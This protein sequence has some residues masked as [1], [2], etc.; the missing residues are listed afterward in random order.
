MKPALVT[1]SNSQIPD[2]LRAQFDV[3]VVPIPV[4]VN[5]VDYLEGIDL[6]ADGFYEFFADGNTPEVSTSQP[7]PG[8]FVAAYQRCIDRGHDEIV[9]VHVAEAFSG[10]INAARI[11]AD[12]VD[13]TVHLVDSATASFGV[14]CCAWQAGL[15]RDAGGDATA[16]VAA[17]ETTAERLHSVTALGAAALLDQSGRVDLDLSDDG[18]HMF[19]TGPGGAFDSIG[20]ATTVD[21]VCDRVAGAMHLDGAPIRVALG[22]ADASSLPYYGEL[23]ARL[24]ERDD[25]IEILRYRIGPSVGALTG[26]GTAGGFWYAA[27]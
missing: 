26:P 7:S 27:D 4:V 1:D 15:V 13:A 20:T 10:T 12:L 2:S 6:D 8:D 25:V 16:M 19:T 9:S 18:I 5:D 24:K 14:A 23:E 17:A 3:R 22:V 21:D 11:A